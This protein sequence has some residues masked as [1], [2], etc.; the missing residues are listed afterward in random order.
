MSKNIQT[1]DIMAYINESKVSA[2][3]FKHQKAIKAASA[4]LNRIKGPLKTKDLTVP[5]SPVSENQRQK[6]S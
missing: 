4:E 2:K 3:Y 5:A 1:D 6:I